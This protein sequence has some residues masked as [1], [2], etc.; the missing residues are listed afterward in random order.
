MEKIFYTDK[1]A[2]PDSETAVRRICSEYFNIEN[3]VILRNENGKPFL[4]NPPTPLFF[5]VSHTENA[6]LVAFS[7]ENVGV[8][9]ESLSRNVDYA[10]VLSRFAPEE[11]KEI[12][13]KADFLR[14]WVAKESAIKW[15][16]GSLAHDLRKIRYAKGRLFCG[17]IELPAKLAF[18]TIESRLVA[19]CSE[20][21][22]KNAELIR[23]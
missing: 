17:E 1:S 22:F 15:L 7:D 12:L 2:Y 4:S 8:D 11:R 3:A 23:F 20:R 14:F 18:H 10:P 9:V 19:V 16:G 6:L 21:D 13:S 5:S